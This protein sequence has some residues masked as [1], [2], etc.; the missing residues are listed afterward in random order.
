M[1]ILEYWTTVT[2]KKNNNSGTQVSCA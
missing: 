1:H 2:T